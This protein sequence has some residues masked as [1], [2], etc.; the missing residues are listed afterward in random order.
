MLYLLGLFDHPI[1]TQVLKVLWRE[2]IPGLTAQKKTFW[3][4]LFGKSSKLGTEELKRRRIAIRNLR[5]GHHLLSQHP[6]RPDL[7][8]CYP[9]IREYFGRQLQK[10]QPA[11]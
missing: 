3:H 10:Q 9:L 2:P 5:D 7:L 8:D 4:K 1:E 6:G 11:A